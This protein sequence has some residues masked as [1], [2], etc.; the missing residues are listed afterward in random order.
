MTPERNARVAFAG[1]Y[2]I[3]GMSVL[4][5]A[6][7]IT[8]VGNP[9]ALDL[10]ERRYAAVVG[11]TSAKFITDVLPHAQLIEVSDYDS[12]VQRVIDGRVDALFADHLVCAVAVW[13]HPDAGLSTLATPFTVEPLGIALPPDAPLLLNLVENYLDT[14]DA[15]G[16][17]TTLQG[18][19]AGR[20]P[21]ARR[22]AL[23]RHARRA[24]LASCSPPCLALACRARLAPARRSRPAKPK[25]TVLM[26]EYDDA[27]VGRETAVD[28]KA[29]MGV[30]E[31]PALAAYVDGIGRK[32]LRGIPL[33]GFDYQFY[34][35]DMI[36]PN[37]FALPG[38]YIFIS[39]G[40]LALANNE[41]ELAC[42]IGHEITHAAR[43]HA[44]AQQ[45]L[46]SRLPPLMMPGSAA[47]FASYSREMER[48]AD[49]GGQILC[50]AA[51]YDPMGM[52]TFLTSLAMSTRLRQGYTREPALLRHAPGLGGARGGQRRARARDPLAARSGARRSARRAAART[53]TGSRSSSAPRR[54]C[55]RATASCTRRSASRCA[56]R[57]AGT[58]RNTTARSGASQPRGEAIVFLSR[59]RA[60]GRGEAGRPR[61]WVGEA[62]GAGAHRGRGLEAGQGRRRSTPGAWTRGP[63]ARAAA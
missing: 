33:R 31:D 19:V 22:D 42:V 55:S 17:L 30:L 23:S 58:S 63:P 28:V 53:S 27:R 12:G 50:A 9:K 57:P 7:A 34:V 46:Q 36:E 45:A 62:A 56:S 49:E 5:K 16:L 29:E 15:T 47:K 25:R 11:S 59:R 43:R 21:L 44:A 37:A 51:G 52:S 41:D 54:A 8:D 2:F 14:L 20:R 40:L 3:S 39:R 13:R 24:P 60:A 61:P 38:G 35:V 26:T 48:E 6:R 10:G 18:E 32:L 1:P 4:A